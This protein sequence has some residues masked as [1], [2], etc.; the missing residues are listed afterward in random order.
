LNVNHAEHFDDDHPSITDPLAK[1][2]TGRRSS[3]N[4]SMHDGLSSASAAVVGARDSIMDDT[5]GLDFSNVESIGH[6]NLG[7]S[8]R[9][10]GMLKLKILPHAN[11]PDADTF[12]SSY[13][14]TAVSKLFRKHGN[15]L[16]KALL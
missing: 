6:L 3:F 14:T 13:S 12:R 10:F 15:V 1:T 7:L 16:R 11:Q 4:A 9:F 2:M 8:L 5:Y